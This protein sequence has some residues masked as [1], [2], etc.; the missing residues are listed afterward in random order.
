GD[1]EVRGQMPE[2]DS[3]EMEEWNAQNEYKRHVVST[4]PKEEPKVETEKRPVK[5]N[6][7]PQS[8][9]D[10]VVKWHGDGLEAAESAEDLR[11]ALIEAKKKQLAECRITKD[12]DAIKDVLP[13]GMK[14]NLDKNGNVCITPKTVATRKVNRH[15]YGFAKPQ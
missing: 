3:D 2:S 12:P 10:G 15:P 8:P 5:T 9:A 7:E 4:F 11:D 1:K 13:V 6:V 14:L